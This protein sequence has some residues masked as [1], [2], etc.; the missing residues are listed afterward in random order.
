[1]SRRTS[2]S[3]PGSCRTR[4]NAVAPDGSDVRVLLRLSRGSMA[5]FELAPGR[6]SRAVA[7]H[8][9]EELWYVL[10]GQ[11]QM[12]RR[13]GERQQTGAAA[14]RHLPVGFRPAPTSSSGRPPTARC[15][16]WA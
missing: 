15:R 6:V 1:M 13:Q 7:H 16:P 2:G 10:G 11:G 9:V 3:T 14:A 5:H 12:W 4:P 8:A